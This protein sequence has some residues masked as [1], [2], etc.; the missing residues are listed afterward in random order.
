MESYRELV[1]NDPNLTQAQK[2]DVL[3]L[4]AGNFGADIISADI[5]EAEKIALKAKYDNDIVAYNSAI[6]SIDALSDVT[7]TVYKDLTDIEALIALIKDDSDI[8]DELKSDLVATLKAIATADKLL[9]DNDTIAIAQN[10][11]NQ[12]LADLKS[13]LVSM[14]NM[15]QPGADETGSTKPFLAE[16]FIAPEDVVCELEADEEKVEDQIRENVDAPEY[17]SDDNKIVYEVYENGTTFLLNFNN[18]QVM[19]VVNNVT[20]T[21]EAYGYIVL[22]NND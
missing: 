11:L 5:I 3:A 4:V 18:Y 21:L 13:L 14:I 8:N 10:M 22:S 15:V 19:V 16:T 17:P 6:D 1:K 12:Q 7:K 2:D 20:Y 9:K